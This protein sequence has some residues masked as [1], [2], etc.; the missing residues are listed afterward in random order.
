MVVGGETVLTTL[1]T[2]ILKFH[3][4]KKKKNENF[5]IYILR[6]IKVLLVKRNPL[7]LL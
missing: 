3:K 6:T 1:L 4:I 7:S 5:Y 2:G